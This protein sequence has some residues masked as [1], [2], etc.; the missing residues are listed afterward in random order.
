MKQLFVTDLDHTFLHTTQTVSPF[1]KKVWNEK[2]EED[3]LSIAT[4]RS[5][6]KTEQFLQGLKLN[7]PLILLDGAMVVTPERELIELKTLNREL[8]DMI[9]DEG[10]KFKIEPFVIALKSR[11]GLSESFRV[12]KLL[13]SYQSTLIQKSYFQDPRVTHHEKM[14]GV[15]DT[16][17]VV[18]IG[19]EKLL[20]ELSERVEELFGARVEIKLAPEKYMGCYFL[21]ILH[22]LADKAHALKRVSSYLNIPLKNITVFGD[23]LNDIG[24][25]KIA[26]TSVAV[27]NAL[28]AVKRE[29]TIVLPHT[30]DEDGVA[31]YLLKI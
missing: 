29:A 15:P 22:P 24:M 3:I 10:R 5:F 20:Q 18:Y 14:F 1:S 2:A 21:T 28:E 13:N 7:A 9:I 31:K 4:A 17:K 11:N 27:K 19:E 16:L 12:P 30:N 8:V 25:F 26:G 23:S 6:N